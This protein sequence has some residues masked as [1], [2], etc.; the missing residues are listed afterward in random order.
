M[1]EKNIITKSSQTNSEVDALQE[2]IDVL[3]VEYRKVYEQLKPLVEETKNILP[4][5]EYHRL[6]E[7]F[8]NLSLKN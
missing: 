4:P 8:K 7:E 3:G 6:L 1:L 5:D 2:K